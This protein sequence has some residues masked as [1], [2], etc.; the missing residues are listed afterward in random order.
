MRV[1]FLTLYPPAAASPRYR[2]HQF[3]PALESAGIEPTVWSA[4]D[5]STWR[6]HSGPDR[7]GRA[8]WYHVYETKQRL[9]QLF[10]ARPFD[11]VVLQKAVMSAYVRGLAGLLRSRA[12]RLVYDTSNHRIR[13]ATF[14][15]RSRTASK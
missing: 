1:L 14:G 6:R 11:V 8:G 4:V 2:V 15:G 9:G 7:V 3:F 12:K 5:E 10:A 13:F